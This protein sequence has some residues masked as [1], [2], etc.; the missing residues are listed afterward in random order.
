[1]EFCK[2]NW[3]TISETICPQGSYSFRLFK[4]RDFFHDLFK[5]SKTLGLVVTFKNVHN[6]RCLGGIF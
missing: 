2:H 1:M 3:A 6:F 5:F 4:L